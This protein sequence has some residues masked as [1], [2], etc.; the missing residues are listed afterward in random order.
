MLHLDTRDVRHAQDDISATHERGPE[1]IARL[2]PLLAAAAVLDLRDGEGSIRL[3]HAARV[4]TA[5][6]VA[7]GALPVHLA[8]GPDDAPALVIRSVA[9]AWRHVTSAPSR[10]EQP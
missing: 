1:A 5:A 7:G 3:R 2:R 4:T 6:L 9:A 8:V 10:Q